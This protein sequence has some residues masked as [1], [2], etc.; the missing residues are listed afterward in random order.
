MSSPHYNCQN[1]VTKYSNVIIFL[2][3][4]TANCV[5][6]SIPFGNDCI[7]FNQTPYKIKVTRTRL[8]QLVQ[9]AQPAPVLPTGSKIAENRSS[10]LI[11]QIRSKLA[12]SVRQGPNQ[13]RFNQIFLNIS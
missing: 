11:G 3:H 5:E 2:F 6:W 4:Y 9:P 1:F 8:D 13:T 7:T 10:Y 12:D